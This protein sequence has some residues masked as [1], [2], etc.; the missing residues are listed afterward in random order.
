MTGAERAAEEQS[1]HRKSTFT[2]AFRGKTISSVDASAINC[3][4]FH[5]TDGTK[6]M[7]EVESAIAS[8]GLYGI[9][10]G[11]RE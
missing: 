4:T 10:L 5:F 9:F 8:I 1:R 7:I 2:R 11:P 3:V 6:Q